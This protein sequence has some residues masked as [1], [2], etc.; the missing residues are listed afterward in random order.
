MNTSISRKELVDKW[1]SI[2]GSLPPKGL[3]RHT[4]ELAVSYHQQAINEGGL[5]ADTCQQL[6]STVNCNSDPEKLTIPQITK[7]GARL[8]REWNGDT[9]MVD[10]LE[11]GYRWKD[12]VYKSLSEI[13]REITST[14]WSGPRFFGLRG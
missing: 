3:G 2:Y 12:K 4:L 6:V 7:P 9:Y 14:R 1:C 10:I 8:V 13:A 5:P 11:E